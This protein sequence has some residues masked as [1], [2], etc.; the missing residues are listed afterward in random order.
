MIVFVGFTDYNMLSRDGYW[1][2]D[3]NSGGHVVLRRGGL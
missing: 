2:F 1:G 3:P